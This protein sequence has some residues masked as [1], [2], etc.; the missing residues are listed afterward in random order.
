MDEPSLSVLLLGVF[1]G[2]ILGLYL[3]PFIVRLAFWLERQFSGTEE[4]IKQG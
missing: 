2:V 3:H 1:I 4:A